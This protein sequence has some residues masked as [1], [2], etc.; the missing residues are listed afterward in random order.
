MIHANCPYCSAPRSRQELWA[1]PC[2]QHGARSVPGG[3]RGGCELM[4]KPR[5]GTG[6]DLLPCTPLLHAEQPAGTQNS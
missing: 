3:H 2:P 4:A 1:G 6:Q 5:A